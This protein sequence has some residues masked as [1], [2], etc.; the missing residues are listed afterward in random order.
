MCQL[1][2]NNRSRSCCWF[3][4]CMQP[5]IPCIKMRIPPQGQRASS[6]LSCKLCLMHMFQKSDLF[7]CS[8][9]FCLFVFLVCCICLFVCCFVCRHCTAQLPTLQSDGNVSAGCKAVSIVRVVKVS[10][11]AANQCQCRLQSS[12]SYGSCI[13]VDGDEL[14]AGVI[15]HMTTHKSLHVAKALQ[16]LSSSQQ[17]LHNMNMSALERVCLISFWGGNDAT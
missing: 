11:Q 13:Y 4:P 17:Q 7:V 12:V 9:L 8:K 5:R 3:M 1:C 10:V 15:M 16:P 6:F 14:H 2:V